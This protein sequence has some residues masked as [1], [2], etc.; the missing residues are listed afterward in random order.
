MLIVCGTDFSERSQRGTAA[1]A[2]LASRLGA[3]IALVHV[4]DPGAGSFDAEVRQAVEKAAEQRLAQEADQLRARAGVEVRHARLE[5]VASDELLGYA[6]ANEADLIVV[7]SSG[8]GASPLYQ[9]GG[10]S[11][12]LAQSTRIPSLVV[13]DAAPFEAWAAGKRPLR[14]LLG[15]DWTRSCEAAIGWVKLLRGV[16]A[17]DVVIGYVYYADTE[18]SD[19]Y[20]LPRRPI[21]AR[22]PEAERLLVRDLASR[23]GEMG[24]SGEVTF[25]PQLGVGRL[26]DHL[27][28]LA[29]AERVDL[30]V[31][32]THQKRGLARLWSV[33]GVTL[34]HSHTS[35]AIVPLPE[36]EL[37]APDEVPRIA[38]VLIATDLSAL[39]NYAVPFG[40]A[41]LGGRG[42]EVWLLHVLDGEREADTLAEVA[43]RLRAVVPR[44]GVRDDVVTRTEVVRQAGAAQAICEAAERLGVDA[45]CMGSHGRT[46]FARTIVGSVCD[47]VLRESRRPVFVVRPLHP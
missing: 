15:V 17:C 31:L 28:D 8:H 38:R 22:D 29:D 25:R 19:R 46:G 14:I 2:A 12:R 30:V 21:A 24:G 5:G 7:A 3:E 47:A 32:G 44:R 27:L 10:T 1:A 18:G 35:V 6:A 45:I 34:H 40:Y 39:S 4:V 9:L 43:A 41:L 26:G 20:G 42:G 13:R 11:E 33:A 23:V 16:Q 36:G 37:L